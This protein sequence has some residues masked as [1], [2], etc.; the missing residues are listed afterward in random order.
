VAKI[1][2]TEVE[3][4]RVDALDLFERIRIAVPNGN[5]KQED[6]RPLRADLREDLDEVECPGLVRLVRRINEAIEPG[7]ELV[8][9]QCRWA[10]FEHLEQQVH[11][12]DLRLGAAAMFPS[13]AVCFAVRMLIKEHIPQERKALLVQA[14][15][16]DLQ[17]RPKRQ[18]GQ[19]RI[20]QHLSPMRQPC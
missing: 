18:A 6:V 3:Q 2:A 13:A 20:A 9:D 11:R 4:N 7:L 15:C 16:N 17:P 8:E 1:G 12:R 10:L 14:C 19:R 5:D